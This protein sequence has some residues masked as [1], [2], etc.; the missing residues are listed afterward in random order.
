MSFPKTRLR[1]LRSFPALRDRVAETSLQPTDMIMPYFVRPGKGIKNEIPSMPGIYQMSVDALVESCEELCT[2]GVKSIILFG[3]PSAKDPEGTEAYAEDGIIQTT[4]RELSAR[5]A[6]LVICTDVCL[7]EYTDHGHC[8]LIKDGEVDNDATEAAR[9]K[10][11][12]SREEKKEFDFGP[13]PSPS[14]LSKQIAEERREFD[15]SLAARAEL[16]A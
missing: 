8:G 14:E 1:R 2:T 9:A 16:G 15:A 7:C 13:L 11:R 3:I 6:D 4:I 10:A 5:L 12:D